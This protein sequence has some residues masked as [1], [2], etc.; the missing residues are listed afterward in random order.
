MRRFYYCTYTLYRHYPLEASD[1][2]VGQTTCLSVNPGSRL[3]ETLRLE[4]WVVGQR[5][6]LA[7]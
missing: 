6:N 2:N 7:E 5:V 3:I 4:P 1:V